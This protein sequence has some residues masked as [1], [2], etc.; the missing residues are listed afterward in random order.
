MMFA[1]R[2]MFQQFSICTIFLETGNVG[3]PPPQTKCGTNSLCIVDSSLLFLVRWK[4]W[5]R[6]LLRCVICVLYLERNVVYLK[7]TPLFTLT[8]PDRLIVSMYSEHIISGSF[9]TSHIASY[10]VI[11]LGA[12]DLFKHCCTVLITSFSSPISVS[13]LK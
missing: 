11:V 1:P 2:L 12:T 4:Y 5:W 9:L 10:F 6:D 7:F 8:A 3:C 13:Q